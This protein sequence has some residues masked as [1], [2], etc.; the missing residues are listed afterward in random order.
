M[1]ER[2][3]KCGHHLQEVVQTSSTS[4][5]RAKEGLCQEEDPQERMTR[6]AHECERAGQSE[7]QGRWAEEKRRR[8]K[9]LA[10][11]RMGREIVD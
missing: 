8:K 7:L 9:I 11:E 1:R 3:P 5:A 2:H 4:P 10:I 6:R